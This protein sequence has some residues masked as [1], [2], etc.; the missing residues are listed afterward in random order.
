M[1]KITIN[2]NNFDSETQDQ[3]RRLIGENYLISLTGKEKSERTEARMRKVIGESRPNTTDYDFKFG[4]DNFFKTDRV[5]LKQF[6]AE[7]TQPK[8]Q[9]VKP[10]LYDKIIVI[11]EFENK[12]LWYLLHTSKIS[13]IAGKENKEVGK[14]TLTRQHKGNEK[15]GQISYNKIFIKAAIFIKETSKIDY[16]KNDLGISDE[17]ILEILEFTKNH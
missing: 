10:D 14:L 3:I 12:T 15:E 9:Q 13:R 5:E 7:G 4:E 17:D 6:D 2:L 11:A 1:N 16:K 8:L